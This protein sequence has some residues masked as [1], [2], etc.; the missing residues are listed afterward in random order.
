MKKLYKI[1]IAI[2]VFFFLDFAISSLL[3]EGLNKGFGLRQESEILI[4]G[5]SHMMM[6]VD[7]DKL[8]KGLKCKISKYTRT[9]SKFTRTISND[10]TVFKLKILKKIKSSINRSGCFYF[11]RR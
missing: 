5:H 3:K 8:E 9:W 10:S 6:G 2:A 11:F 7:R 1:L 4:V